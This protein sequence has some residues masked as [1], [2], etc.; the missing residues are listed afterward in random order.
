MVEIEDCAWYK[1]IYRALS[2]VAKLQREINEEV[3]LK[4][5]DDM[6]EA[7][8]NHETAFVDWYLENGKGTPTYSDAIEWARK[9]VINKACEW[10]KENVEGGVHPQSAYGFVDNF[11]KEME[12]SMAKKNN[13]GSRN[14]LIARAKKSWVGDEDVYIK[15]LRDDLIDKEDAEELQKA[16]ERFRKAIEKAMEE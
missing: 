11:R 3:R 14:G 9:E 7:E 6:T 12:K 1:D 15:N 16:V 5:C 2:E 10:L 13:N 4:K 8:Y